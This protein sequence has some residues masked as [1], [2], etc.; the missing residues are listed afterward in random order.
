M[1]ELEAARRAAEDAVGEDLVVDGIG[2]T[3]VGDDR[4]AGSRCVKM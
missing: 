3:V 4:L 2:V 1:H